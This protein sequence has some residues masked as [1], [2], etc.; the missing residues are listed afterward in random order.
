MPLYAAYGLTIASDFD[1][2]GLVAGDGEADVRLRRGELGAEY[3]E[4]T[5]SGD[6]ILGQVQGLP[7]QFFAQNGRDVTV[8]VAGSIPDDAVA[9]AILGVVMGTVLRQRGYLVLHASCVARDDEAVAFVGYSG[10]GK[11]TTA[12]YFH[13]H[14]YR[15]ISD[16]VLAIRVEPTPRVYPGYPLIKLRPDAGAQLRDDFAEM[17]LVSHDADKRVHHLGEFSF[18]P[19]TLRRVYLLRGEPSPE[20]RIVAVPPQRAMMEFVG[21]TLLI[22]FLRSPV[23]MQRHLQQCARLISQVPVRALERVMQLDTLADIKRLVEA[24]LNGAEIEA[25]ATAP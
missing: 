4:R 18:E 23:Y 15:L 25:L 11:S 5:N 1:L 3:R 20:N 16:D 14:G 8:D 7:I 17:P 10:W 2:P 12:E 21:H 19:V 24:D 6:E 9:G 13:Q 22:T